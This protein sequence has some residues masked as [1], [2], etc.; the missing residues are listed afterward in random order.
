M[1]SD[2]KSLNT[3]CKDTHSSKTTGANNK[4][5]DKSHA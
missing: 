5:L 3:I 1:L 4:K 2:D